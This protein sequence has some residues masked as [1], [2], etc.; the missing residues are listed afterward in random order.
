MCTHV[1]LAEAE[2]GPEDRRS[3]ALEQ[4]VVC[5]K[6]PNVL[7][8][9]RL[10][11]TLDRRLARGRHLPYDSMSSIPRFDV[12]LQQLS[13]MKTSAYCRGTLP[14]GDMMNRTNWA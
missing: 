4:L 8:A 3:S 14:I 10:A 6:S 9:S 13:I 12:L 7:S 2:H 1:F 11:E 5:H